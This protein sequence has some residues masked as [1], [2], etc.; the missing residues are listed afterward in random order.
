MSEYIRSLPFVEDNWYRDAYML[1]FTVSQL[2]EVQEEEKDSENNNNQAKKSKK[3]EKDEEYS[4]EMK[5]L[6]D[7]G[8]T[9]IPRNKRA[10]KE[11][12][13]DVNKAVQVLM[14]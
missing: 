1:R 13:N 4:S 12:G 14:D 2:D 7:M 6:I 11:N 8:F 9:D 5:Q 10:L 3:Q